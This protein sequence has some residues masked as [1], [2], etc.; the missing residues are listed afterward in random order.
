MQKYESAQLDEF[1][2]LY[3]GLPGWVRERAREA[4]QRFKDDPSHPGLN[5]EQLGCNAAWYS[6]RITGKYRA[7][8][9]VDGKRIVWFWI[10]SHT[11]FDKKFQ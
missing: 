9:Q 5:F 6:V 7:V 2:K 8:G 1:W 11:D 4:Y 10:G 3:Y